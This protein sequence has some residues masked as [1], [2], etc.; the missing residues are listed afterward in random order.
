MGVLDKLK[1]ITDKLYPLLNS[2]PKVGQ[3]SSVVEKVQKIITTVVSVLKEVVSACNKI[4]ENVSKH[5]KTALEL[6]QTGISEF[7]SKATTYFEGMTKAYNC[8]SRCMYDD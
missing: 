6:V 8:K 2:I 7:E 3:V 5:A 1:D 4:H